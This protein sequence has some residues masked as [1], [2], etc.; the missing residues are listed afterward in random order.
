[1]IRKFS[2]VVMILMISGTV[3][4][5]FSQSGSKTETALSQ[6]MEGNFILAKKTA[7]EVISVEKNNAL[8]YAIRA[9]GLVY[10][11]QPTA[12]Q[13][14][15]EKAIKLSP[16]NG[17]FHAFIA[18]Y[19]KVQ[20]N[21]VQSKKSA[22]KA[23]S[24]LRSPRSA[25]D[26]FARAVAWSALDKMDDA[27]ADYS[28]TIELNP[29]YVRAYA[30][31]GLIYLDNKQA[32]LAFSDFSKA[33][34]IN[35]RYAYPYF[36]RGN[37]YYE[38][39]KH[40]LAIADYTKVIELDPKFTSAYINRGVMYKQLQKYEPALADYAKAIE[41]N[42][43]DPDTYNN[44]GHVY[45]VQKEYDLAL[46]QYNKAIELDPKLSASYMFRGNTYTRK[47]QIE[48]AV[49]DHTRAI[50]LNPKYADPYAERGHIYYN[51]KMYDLALKDY[52]KVTELAPKFSYGY[53]WVG[54]TYHE[55]QQYSLAI[56]NYTKAIEL[57][58]KNLYA[59]NNRADAYES[60]G[61]SKQAVID[62]KSYADLGGKITASGS[63]TMKSIFPAG[64]FNPEL[65]RAALGRG[66]S[67]IRG[68]A[69]TKFDGLRFDA[70]GVKVLLFPVTP[71]LEEWYELRQKK[72]G[73]KTSVYMSTE[74]NQYSIQTY[75]DGDGRFMFEGLKPGKY[76]IQ[77]IH[78]FNQAKSARIYTGSDTHQNGPVRTT[79]NYYYDQDYTVARSKRLEKFVEIKEDGETKKITMT[80]G[81]IKSCAF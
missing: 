23:I 22:E 81:L 62:R 58:P 56:T 68:K 75:A 33:I 16:D 69:C 44:R 60:I 8:A 31:R 78:S 53:S 7:S 13:S 54:V 19:Y 57:D 4:R 45:F 20:W 76:F 10:D 52:L 40:E 67:T 50:E 48:E 35:P 55:K 80:T 74:A 9:G 66:L 49:K 65:A 77:I 70:S 1:M 41:L 2:F 47:E 36:V 24:L 34:E 39:Q 17:V 79:T 59:Y 51:N 61:N 28:K 25:L 5:S 73:K 63:N 3:S 37:V 26:Y 72:E 21:A 32:D 29:R 64:S 43:K 14:D 42:P 11:N 15:L 18:D 12:A 6:L 46:E 30:K 38:R 71:Y 27:L